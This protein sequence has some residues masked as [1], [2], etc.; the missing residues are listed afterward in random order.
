MKAARVISLDAEWLPFRRGRPEALL[1]QLG[2]WA[3]AHVDILLVVSISLIVPG[4]L[5]SSYF[6]RIASLAAQDLLGVPAKTVQEVLQDFLLHDQNLLVGYGL[7]TDLLA[8][9]FAP[10]SSCLKLG[11]DLK[12]IQLVLEAHRIPGLPK[13][14][15]PGLSALVEAYLGKELDK[16]QQC[17]DWGARPLSKEQKEYAAADAACLLE[18]VG[19]MVSWYK[20]NEPLSREETPCSWGCRKSIAWPALPATC[21][22]IADEW[23]DCR[24]RILAALKNRPKKKKC[25][26]VI[27]GELGIAA[28]ESPRKVTKVLL[29]LLY[30]FGMQMCV[31]PRSGQRF[32]VDHLASCVM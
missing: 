26:Q 13:P 4:M 8:I 11:I 1:V 9:G 30:P 3:P 23:K 22:R 27:E 31:L 6:Q 12:H 20:G 5:T 17:S 32:P 15:G 24:S 16:S 29:V 10:S 28:S 19:A 21:L 7:R 2:V 25:K 14:G 18:L